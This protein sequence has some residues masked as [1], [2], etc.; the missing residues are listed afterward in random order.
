MFDN[1]KKIEIRCVEISNCLGFRIV[2]ICIYILIY[3]YIVC[4]SNNLVMVLVFVYFIVCC[5]L[6]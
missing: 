5:Y 3:Y 6:L 4:E 1:L 2:C